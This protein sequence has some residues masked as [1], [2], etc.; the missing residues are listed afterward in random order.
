MNF[1]L[2]FT[3]LYAIIF[4]ISVAQIFTD[5]NLPI[6]IINTDGGVIIPDDPRVLASMKI[7]NRGNGLRNRVTDQDSS[8][9]LNYDGRINIEIRGSSSQVLPKKQYGFTTLKSDNTSNRNVSLLGL[10]TENDWILNGLGFDPSLIRDYISYNLSRR[11][12][13]YAT[14]TV[15]C[16]VILNGSYNGLYVLQEKIKA[17]NDRVDVKKISTSDKAFPEVTGGY[18]TKADK[19][20]G[21]DP[22]AWTMPSYNT[23]KSVLFIHELPKPENVTAEQNNYI[24]GEFEKLYYLSLEKN[25]SATAGW[26]SVIDVSS[27]IDYM[28]LNEYSANSDAY[29]YSTFFH[30][31]R[32]GKLRAGPIWDHNLT[33]GNDLTLWGFDRSK[34]DTWQFANGDNTGARFWKELFDDA[35]Y[36]CYLSKRFNELIQPGMPLNQNMISSFIDSTA[37]LINEA[38][39]RENQRW[40]TVNNFT[41]ELAKI[42]D[43]IG[44]RI[45]WMVS[46]LGSA[47]AC[48]SV[49]VPQ[50]VISR[51]M[52]SPAASV[53]FTAP[54]DLEFIEVTNTGTSDVV[55]SGVF[56][57]GTG[58]VYQFPEYSSLPAGASVKIAS[59]AVV[60]RNRYGVYPFGQFT[61]N[62][63]DKGEKLIMSDAFGN[64]IDYVCY[65]DAPPWPDAK[66][67]GK[68]LNLINLQSDNNL[69]S[70]WEAIENDILSAIEINPESLIK[71]Y[72]SPVT[73]KLVI[74][75]P[76]IISEVFIIDMQG[77]II[78]NTI[79]GSGQ[80]VIDMNGYSKG[81]YIIKLVSANGNYFRKIIKI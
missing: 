50:L 4:D 30:K 46:N 64:I 60:F 65:S 40:S 62:L 20:T 80:V 28:I 1:R 72:P 29:Q 36:R 14:R 31:D 78:M 66:A 34:Y 77:H 5:S 23:S 43:F 59:N 19:T 76:E 9:L 6:V 10:P 79:A 26:P 22:V 21:G 55:L 2:I 49:K 8:K 27:F 48:N 15:F 16:E 32:N 57:A 35:V 7:I 44:K 39:A 3:I 68:Y 71:I 81:I 17:G 25:S 69:G 56:F 74:E 41:G 70:N 61:R 54:D 33:L 73:D 52:Y 24:K 47:S 63:S 12:G 37:L 53:E 13:Q 75:H 11:V 42:K 58:F 45:N 38:V 18:I 67:N 51:I